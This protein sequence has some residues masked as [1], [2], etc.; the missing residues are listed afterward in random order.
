[1][2]LVG[3][4]AQVKSDSQVR[5]VS[6]W[7]ENEQGPLRIA[8]GG[9]TLTTPL[10]RG[11]S[12]PQQLPNRRAIPTAHR[13]HPHSDVAARRNVRAPGIAAVSRCAR[14]RM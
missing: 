8:A 4:R 11:H 6:E 9:R 14:A 13:P 7:A 2:S 5:M 3:R 12:G 1:M 10:A